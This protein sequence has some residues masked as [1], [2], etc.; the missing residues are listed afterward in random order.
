VSDVVQVGVINVYDRATGWATAPV[1]AVAWTGHDIVAW[2]WLPRSDAAR[3]LRVDLD[4]LDPPARARW[5]EERCEDPGIIHGVDVVD[6]LVDPDL[7]A[8]VA[9]VEDLLD[10]VMVGGT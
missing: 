4:T 2:S 3:Q 5:L 1:A 10:A 9:A 6:V 8:V 7:A